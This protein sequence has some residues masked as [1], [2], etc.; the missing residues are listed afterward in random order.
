M[1]TF[2]YRACRGTVLPSFQIKIMHKTFPTSENCIMGL[3]TSGNLCSVCNDKCTDD[4]P[5]FF[6]E[7]SALKSFWEEVFRADGIIFHAET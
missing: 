7:C 2:P 3:L 4:T 1:C 6:L 5:H